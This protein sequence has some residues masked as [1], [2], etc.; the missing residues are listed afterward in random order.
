[1]DIA[2]CHRLISPTRST[3]LSP[4]RKVIDEDK[5]PRLPRLAPLRSA[6]A[7]LAPEPPRKLLPPSEPGDRPRH[8]R[9]VGSGVES[10]A[11]A[12]DAPS[13]SSF[14]DVHVEHGL[15]GHN[16]GSVDGGELGAKAFSKEI[17]LKTGQALAEFCCVCIHR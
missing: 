13:A 6:L 12:L 4:L 2:T 8:G 3:P 11:R 5:Y 7:K 1:M 9:T 14:V 17:A 16:F 15:I 10:P